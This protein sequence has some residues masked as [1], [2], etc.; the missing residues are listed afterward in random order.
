LSRRGRLRAL[1][2][3]VALALP[4]VLAAVAEARPGG[5]HG[6]SSGSRSG[7]GSGSDAGGA[8]LF[9]LVFWI[10]RLCFMYPKIG[11]P[12]LI[13]VAFVVWYQM[14]SAPTEN[15]EATGSVG[16]RE[17]PV[18]HGNLDVVKRR[19]PE[20]STVL[21]RDFLYAL[22]ARAH[23]S[24]GDPAALERLAPYVSPEARV[25]L[26]ER[27]P[28]GG[29]VQAAIVG[30][31]HV[32]GARH[33]TEDGEAWITAI[34]VFEANILVTGDEGALTEYAVERWT[35]RRA[36][37]AVTRA[38]KGARGFGCP[39]CGAPLEV[40]G[41]EQCP[42]CGQVVTDARFDWRVDT[43]V[44]EESRWL[45]PS[46]TGTV[47]EQGTDLPTI[48]DPDCGARFAELQADDPALTAQSI[49]ARLRLVFAEVNAAWTAL[50]LRGARPFV[51]DGVYAYL[52]YWTDA[53]RA[54]GLRNTVEGARITSLSVVK[55]ERDRHY[56][57]I[58][59]RI[60]GTGRDH[61]IEDA[62]GKVVG[63]SKSRD[64]AYSE[65]WTLVRGAQ[66]RGAARADKS[67]PNCG[68]PLEVN[69]TGNCNY[70][71]S[72]VTTGDFDWVLGLIEQD[73]SYSG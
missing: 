4:V 33:G 48:T 68:G 14:R 34:V 45:P 69:M 13:G 44:V 70:C 52:T 47:E 58:T 50:D 26:A 60:F 67:C 23:T 27:P 71:G 73:D 7:G 61:T 42:S 10:L 49:E 3:I 18:P 66:V 8:L 41:Q 19:D 62:T 35:L 46:L 12:F 54:Q 32:R 20:F 21:F 28:V 9:E 57:A 1:A 63:G 55:V 17:D 15:W 6:Y 65:Y 2:W 36:A 31:L 64:R 5:G 16:L 30:A 25:Q 24:R 39:A 72:L 38:W 43:I 56:D 51:S 29:A 59:I 11:F 22:Y 37:S 53:Y 40:A